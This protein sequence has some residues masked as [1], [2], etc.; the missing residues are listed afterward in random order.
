MRFFLEKD[1]TR[2]RCITGS[3]TANSY[4][5]GRVLECPLYVAENPNNKPCHTDIDILTISAYFNG[6]LTDNTSLQAL[7]IEASQTTDREALM[8]KLIQ[9]IKDG[10][11]YPAFNSTGLA[12]EK[13]SFQKYKKM[14]D[15]Y[16]MDLAIY[17]GGTHITA[18]GKSLQDDPDI[19]DLF[20]ELNKRP[21]MYDIY[22]QLLTDWKK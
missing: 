12:E 17:E 18:N 4:T 13:D 3:Q 15:K 19:I 14:A 8:Q 16:D 9:Q 10:S 20:I 21:E 6:G 11:S 22:T 5:F 7:K 1:K 2:V